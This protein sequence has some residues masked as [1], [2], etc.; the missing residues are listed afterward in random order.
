MTRIRGKT[1]K[2]H[3]EGYVLAF[4]GHVSE[5]SLEERAGPQ[6]NFIT[7][8]IC[9]DVASVQRRSQTFLLAHCCNPG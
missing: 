1:S 2:A 4:N 6:V 8:S 9:L 3:V 7:D 5:F